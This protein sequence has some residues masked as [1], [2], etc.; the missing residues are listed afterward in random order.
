MNGVTNPLKVLPVPVL[1][2]Q[3]HAA[4]PNAAECR[5]NRENERL[6]SL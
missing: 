5:Y 4:H 6:M 1:L 2:R 3:K